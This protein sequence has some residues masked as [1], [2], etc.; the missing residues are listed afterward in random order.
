MSTPVQGGGR[1]HPSHIAT[2]AHHTKVRG[3]RPRVLSYPLQIE[4]AR[5]IRDRGGR[6]RCSIPDSND[7]ST[8]IGGKG[9]T[10]IQLR[11]R[12]REIGRPCRYL[13][14]RKK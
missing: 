14:V 13:F 6:G 9:G 3:P 5:K 4:I 10:Q 2:I 11:E 1:I 7:H 8:Y 12:E